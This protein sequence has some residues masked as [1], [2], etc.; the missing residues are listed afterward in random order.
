MSYRIFNFEK[1]GFTGYME[2]PKERSS[3]AVIVVVGGKKD[4]ITSQDI[5]KQMAHLGYVGFSVSLFG[6]R[7]QPKGI[8]RIPLEM[9]QE[10]VTY[11]K[12]TMRIPHIVVYGYSMGSVVAPMIAR[13]IPGIDGLVMVSGGHCLYEGHI[14]RKPTGHAMLTWQGEELPFLPV[15][16]SRNKTHRA[17]SLAYE[18][19]QA[20]LSSLLPFTELTCPI[21]VM[22]SD[23]DDLWP[24]GYSV[25]FIE[26]TLRDAAYP[27]PWEAILYHNASHMLGILPG[28]D[29]YHS[30]MALI[31]LVS[32][33]ERRYRTICQEAR[34]AS[35]DK[36]LLFF[37]AIISER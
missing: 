36:I 4:W 10:V 3:L 8:D 2:L 9:F 5:A 13:Y 31:P 30:R 19:H 14:N 6:S 22:A 32:Q 21:L 26:N 29:D 11:L 1:H 33:N 18:D 7:G 17:F 35:R 15:D 12:K 23:S 28:A 37:E 20:Q 27:Y 25:K 24:A 34:N 16:L